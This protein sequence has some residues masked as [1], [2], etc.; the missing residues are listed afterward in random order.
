MRQNANLHSDPHGPA[1]RVV[2]QG[3]VLRVFATAP[4]GWYQVGDTAPW[5]WVHESML[6][7]H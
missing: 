3:T 7:K 1:T 2:P 6:E 5:G 4:G